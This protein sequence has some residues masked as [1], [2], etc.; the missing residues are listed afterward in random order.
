MTI[1]I[2]GSTGHLGEALVRLLREEFG[3]DG[4]RG[5]DIQASAFTDVVGSIVDAH[6]CEKAMGGITAVIH[7]ASLHKPHI[8][9]HTRQD[10]VDV[11]ITGTLNLLEAAVKSRTV[12][13]FIFTSTTSSF[14]D[15]LK[16]GPGASAATWIDESVRPKPK[17]I[18]G[19]TKLAAEDLCQLY[20]RLYQLPCLVLKVSRFFP[21]D[22]DSK[23]ARDFCSTDNSK[24]N[25]LLYRRADIY[26]M[27]TAHRIAID[28]AP[29]IG[30]D[31]FI[32][33]G[34]SPFT[35]KDLPELYTD[36]GSKVMSYFPS[37]KRIYDKNFFKYFENIDRVYSS[38]YA[39]KKLGW[40]PVYSFEK[41]LECLDQGKRIGS[42]LSHQVGIKLYHAM[43]FRSEETGGSPY[44]TDISTS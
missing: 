19:I 41:A 34:A 31:R 20:Y 40:E 27:A 24:V 44:P 21:E 9:T 37:M 10:F 2:T 5:L 8:E 35:Q 3:A 29:E 1:L 23:E 22:D 16:P 17:N 13:A 25:E 43:D 15:A 28:R 33:S 12:K 39:R 4:V 26:D 6:V 30:F 32:I 38:A 42:P 36:A 14:G 7:T 18:Y 11:N